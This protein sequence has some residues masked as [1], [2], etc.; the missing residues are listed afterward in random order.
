[1]KYE[2]KKRMA[3]KELLLLM[4]VLLV[5]QIGAS[6]VSKRYTLFVE[7]DSMTYYETYLDQYHGELQPQEFQE[8]QELAHQ[9]ELAEKTR[10]HLY[11][12]LQYFDETT[13]NK[14]EMKATL[15]EIDLFQRK[16][17]AFQKLFQQAT[18][19]QEDPDHRQIIHPLGYREL[20]RIE[21]IQ[22]FLLLALALLVIPLFSKEYEQDTR[23]L[24]ITTKQGKR[25]QFYTKLQFSLMMSGLLIVIF[26]VIRDLPYLLYYSFGDWLAPMQSV[27]EFAQAPYPVSLLA[28]FMIT[29]GLQFLGYLVFVILMIGLTIRCKKF[30]PSMAISC[31][32]VLLCDVI[33]PS[34][35]LYFLPPLALMKGSGLIRGDEMTMINAGSEYASLYQTYIGTNLSYAYPLLLGGL[36]LLFWMIR[37]SAATYHNHNHKH[38]WRSIGYLLALLCLSGCGTSTYPDFE[39]IAIHEVVLPF[40]DGYVIQNPYEILYWN[41]EEVKPLVALDDTMGEIILSMSV[42]DTQLCYV[43]SDQSSAN[44]KDIMSCYDMKTKET[45]TIF[46]QQTQYAQ[47]KLFGLLTLNPLHLD[48][49][50]PLDTPIYF[51]KGAMYQI[52]GENVLKLAGDQ[53]TAVVND[54]YF[55]AV[56]H[57]NSLYYISTTLDLC[58]Y[59]VIKNEKEILSEDYMVQRFYC[60]EDVVYFTVYEE[61]GIFQWKNQTITKVMEEPHNLLGANDTYLYATDQDQ[62]IIL[63]DLASQQAKTLKQSNPSMF[64]ADN[65]HTFIQYSNKQGIYAYDIDM[66]NETLILGETK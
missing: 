45:S 60:W 9:F 1:M 3:S 51:A 46:T 34:P 41:E 52:E 43:T 61:A 49:Q 37:R 64:Y 63:Y 7:Q 30:F 12:Q 8:I 27:P 4:I 54:Y 29:R 44:Q 36:I 6:Y 65:H 58:R 39:H 48:D 24:C 25:H 10:V 31:G 33:L 5:F 18:Y 62:N 13:M 50:V 66:T 20:L 21:T 26:L 14:K 56:L 19:V 22:P 59:D 42:K 35:F 17:A 15:R 11:E 53:K 16:E 47:K 38:R 57:E 23:L 28:A 2:W 40:Q 32:S 55:G